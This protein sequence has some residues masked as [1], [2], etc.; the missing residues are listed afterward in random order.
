MALIKLAQSGHYLVVLCV[1]SSAFAA[2][3]GFRSIT[4]PNVPAGFNAYELFWDG[5]G[6]LDWTSSSLRIDL[7][8]GS[9]YQHPQGSDKPANPFFYGLAPSLEYDTAFGIPGDATGGIP[10]GAGDLGG[11]PFSID[12][13][14]LSVSWFNTGPENLGFER[15]G[16]VTLSDTAVGTGSLWMKG[17]VRDFNISNGTIDQVIYTIGGSSIPRPDPGQDPGPFPQL[18]PPP[19]SSEYGITLQRVTDADVPDGYVSYRIVW[20][21]QGST[22]WK[23]AGMRL[24]LTSGGLYEHPAGT[25]LPPDP[26]FVDSFPGLEYDTYFGIAG[27]STSS[28]SG[29]AL[30]VGDRSLGGNGIF[31]L[32]PPYIDV[33]WYNRETEDTGVVNIG[34]LTLSE[35]ANGLIGLEFQGGVWGGWIAPIQNGSILPEP[36]ALTFCL[37]VTACLIYRHRRH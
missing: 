27:D 37:P 1:C 9:F 25:D 36:A 7:S 12:A 8:V 28:I 4:D 34:M 2:E 15:I 21:G 14:Q 17:E 5:Q 31:N 22:D 10:G 3:Y 35:D 11:G 13:P 32:E 33:S 16:M 18:P 19:S 6:T 30:N 29:G 23:Y 26:T 20:N 24:D